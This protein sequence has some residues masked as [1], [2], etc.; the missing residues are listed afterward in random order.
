MATKYKLIVLK[1]ENNDKYEAQ[2]AEYKEKFTENNR[3]GYRRIH[4]N[5]VE[6]SMV[7][8]TRSLEVDITDKEFEELKGN[9]L[10]LFK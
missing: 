2:L 7:E 1:Y 8:T 4:E 3:D 5:L 6:P 10:T 9:A